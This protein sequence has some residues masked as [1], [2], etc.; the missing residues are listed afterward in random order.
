MCRIIRARHGNWALENMLG[1]AELIWFENWLG[2]PSVNY[3][4]D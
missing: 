1:G 2:V 3:P 4:K